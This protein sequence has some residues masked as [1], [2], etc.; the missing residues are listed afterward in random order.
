MKENNI[1]FEQKVKEG[2]ELGKR[3]L[4]YSF[5]LAKLISSEVSQDENETT[6]RAII[7]GFLLSAAQLADQIIKAVSQRYLTLAI[8][9]SRSLLEFNINA[10]YIFDNPKHK[11]DLKWIDRL[12]SDIFKRTNDIGI[13]K[14]HLGEVSLRT[15]AKEIGRLDLYEINYASLSDYSHLIMRGPLLYRKETAEKVSVATISQA[16]CNLTGVIDS[17]IVFK[18]LKWDKELLKSVESFRDN[19]E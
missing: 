5:E 11:I 19:Y 17:V 16:L 12:C 14:S 15:R 13:L 3:L 9:G 1:P 2:V 4:L 8:I 6:R 18:K 7:K 10:N